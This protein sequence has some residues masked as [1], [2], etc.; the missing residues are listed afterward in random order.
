MPTNLAITDW[1]GR[2]VW[3]VGAS[4]G[5]GAALAVALS[6]RGARLAVSARRA[7]AL[8][9]IAA[10]DML[11]VPMDVTEVESIAAA[12]DS[13]I[14]QWGGCDLVIYLAGDY[15]PLDATSFD[16]PTALRLID[17]NLMGALRLVS[18]VVPI[19]TRGGGVAITASVAGYR[20][21]PKS[22][23]YGAAKAGLI[24]L[25]ESL[26]IDL[27]PLGISVWLINPGFVATRLTDRNDFKMPALIS[28]EIA[29][30]EILSGLAVGSFEIHFPRR[31]TWT[32]KLVR[33][34]PDALYFAL[35]RKLGIAR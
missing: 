7:E 29:A 9:S 11:I 28:P 12:R 14:E 35:L 5:I 15:V 32:M 2:R 16:L 25:T 31:F 22:L 13:V 19:L 18:V 27:R 1:N 34:L 6:A 4:S 23:A 17:I 8:E 26:H 30:D 20:G 21:L 10:P 3:L 33:W 24:N